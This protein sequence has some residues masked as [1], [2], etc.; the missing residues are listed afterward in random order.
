MVPSPGLDL[1]VGVHDPTGGGD[2]QAEGEVG[3]GLLEYAGGVAHQHAAAGSGC[4]VDVVHSHAPVCDDLEG[5]GGVEDAGVHLVVG[6][7]EE[8]VGLRGLLEQDVGRRRAVGL[9][10]LHVEVLAQKIDRFRDP[11]AGHE[12]LCVWVAHTTNRLWKNS[13]RPSLSPPPFPIKEKKCYI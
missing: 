2:H 12:Y 5:R 9:P 7:G 10:C 4:D 1:A 11:P 3:A 6:L 13:S 8:G